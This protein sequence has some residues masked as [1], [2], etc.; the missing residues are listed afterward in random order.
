MLR[1][2]L[3]PATAVLLLMVSCRSKPATIEVRESPVTVKAAM[4]LMKQA[5]SGPLQPMTVEEYRSQRRDAINGFVRAAEDQRVDPLSLKRALE[6]VTPEDAAN[7]IVP[8]RVI[9]APFEGK[10][11][12]IIVQNWNRPGRELSYAKVWAVGLEDGSVLYAASLK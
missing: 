4:G 3:A 5:K 8:V 10:K 9:Q 12:W 7:Q 1:R 6:E 2:F 11:A